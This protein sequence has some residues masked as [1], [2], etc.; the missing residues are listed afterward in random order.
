MAEQWAGSISGLGVCELLLQELMSLTDPILQLGQNELSRDDKSQHASR[1]IE[2]NDAGQQR[3]AI[4]GIG[5]MLFLGPCFK[6]SD[7]VSCVTS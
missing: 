4:A 6:R 5:E 7:A 1:R 3:I 2:A